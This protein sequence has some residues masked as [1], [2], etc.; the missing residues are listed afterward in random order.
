MGKYCEATKYHKGGT[1]TC[2]REKDHK[3][4]H[5]GESGDGADHGIWR[6]WGIVYDIKQEI[7]RSK[8]VVGVED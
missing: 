2:Q 1:F 3:G 8:L 5:L 6:E 4:I 7:R